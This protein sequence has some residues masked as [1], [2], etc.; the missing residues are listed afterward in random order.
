MGPH[1]VFT[2]GVFVCVAELF[3]FSDWLRLN[4][5]NSQY[6]HIVNFRVNCY[7]HQRHPLSS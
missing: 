6:Q 7:S 1:G 2:V 4:H 5:L 3:T